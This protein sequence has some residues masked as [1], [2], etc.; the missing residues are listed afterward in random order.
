LARNG[1]VTLDT[2]SITTPVCSGSI[3]VVKN[4]VNGNGTFAFTSNFGL[5]SLTTVGGTANQT[6]DGLTAGGGFSVSETLPIGWTQSSATCTNGIPAAVI[7]QPDVTTVCTFVNTLG[8]PPLPGSIT[9]VKNTINGDG[10]FAFTSNFGLT[11][12][13]TV[14]GTVSHTFGNLPAGGSFSVSETLP[15]GW[16][17]TSAVCTNGTPAAVIVLPDVT[18]VCTFVNTL[19][20]APPPGSITIV[21]NTVNGNGTFQFT[22]NF[23][24]TS[25]TTAGGTASQT[26]TGLAAGAS[27]SAIEN[28]PA[29]WAQTGATCTNGTTVAITVLSGI[30]TVRTFTNT[31]V[32]PP[33]P[34]F[35]RV[36]KNTVGG[37]GTF[38]FPNNFGATSLTTVDGTASFTFTIPNAGGNFNISETPSIGWTLTSASCD[39]GSLAAITVMPGSITTCT[40]VNTRIA[41][42]PTG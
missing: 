11:S 39:S 42:A 2:N 17:Q 12:V 22:T 3:Q 31:A 40:F 18:T 7:V 24:L 28:V 10:T 8:I 27:F 9:V 34:G 5:A 16:T 33:P 20:I 19:G 23:G 1:A 29:G 25:L 30:S 32:A 35:I 4:T 6:F 37:D 38:S 41:A 14:G 13:T 21:K 15:V 36:V 26:F